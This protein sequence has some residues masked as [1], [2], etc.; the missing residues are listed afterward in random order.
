MGRSRGVWLTYSKIFKMAFDLG[1]I[2]ALS[3]FFLAAISI[4]QTKSQENSTNTE[5]D[6]E[7]DQDVLFDVPENPNEKFNQSFYLKAQSYTASNWRKMTAGDVDDFSQ[8]SNKLEA[9]IRKKMAEVL[10]LENDPNLSTDDMVKIFQEKSDKGEVTSA[11]LSTLQTYTMAM[12]EAYVK[13]VIEVFNLKPEDLGTNP[14]YF[15]EVFEFCEFLTSTTF[16]TSTT[17]TTRTTTITTASTTTKTTSTIPL[18]DDEPL[19]S[20][21]SSTTSVSETT[22]IT[23]PTNSVKTTSKIPADRIEVLP[24]V[25]L[26]KIESDLE[27]LESKV[28]ASGDEDSEASGTEAPLEQIAGRRSDNLN[29][30]IVFDGTDESEQEVEARIPKVKASTG[31]ET[32]S[33]PETDGEPGW[34][35]GSSRTN[36]DIT[37][38]ALL[39]CLILTLSHLL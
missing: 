21:S 12:Q 7:Y 1:R 15:C 3:L 32:D 4:E 34:G 38:K 27:E 17:T 36:S 25:N 14:Q 31:S 24:V 10:G 29:P 5:V 26:T 39:C 11:E 8:Y 13:R 33:E 23:V 20:T 37:S 28:E 22:E 9:G 30:G 18:A 6:T 16:T 2:L 19:S 35:S